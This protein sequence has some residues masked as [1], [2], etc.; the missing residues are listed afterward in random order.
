MERYDVCELACDPFGWHSEIAGWADAYGDVVLE[1]P[2]NQRS[3]MG[4][5]V[6][7]FT[8]AVMTEGVA[9]DGDPRLARHVGHVSRG[10]PRR[11]CCWE[12][13]EGVSAAID[14]AIAGVVAGAA[15]GT[16]PTHRRWSPTSSG[17][18]AEARDP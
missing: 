11:G 3:R 17:R 5:A 18:D 16:R 12:G 13:L 8:S 9:H 1:F 2:T 4:V 6:R 10:R 14:A 7:R 15:A